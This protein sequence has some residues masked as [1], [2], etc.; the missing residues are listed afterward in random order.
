[1][2]LNSPYLSLELLFYRIIIRYYTDCTGSVVWSDWSNCSVTHGTGMQYRYKTSKQKDPV[3]KKIE[4][5]QLT[6]SQYC[7]MMDRMCLYLM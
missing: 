6:E 1:M 7:Q 3:T 2:H 5:V 4:C